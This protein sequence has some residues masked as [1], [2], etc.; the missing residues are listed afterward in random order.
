V[1]SREL[2][3]RQFCHR[4]SLRA[5]LCR[6]R[7]SPASGRA[8][9]SASSG[10]SSGSQGNPAQVRLPQMP[11]QLLPGDPDTI[12]PCRTGNRGNRW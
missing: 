7:R 11:Q 1:T 3:D 12:I 4:W 10:P 6:A 5:R 2:V 8:T 9:A